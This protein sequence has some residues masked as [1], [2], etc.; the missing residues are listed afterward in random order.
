MRAIVRGVNEGR[1]GLGNIY[2]WASGDGGQDDDCNCDGYAA[3]M[4]TISINSA[5]NNGE[6]AHYDESCSSTLASTFSNGAKDPHTGVRNSLYDSKNRFHWNMNGVGLEFNHLFGYGVLD[7]GAMVALAKIW[8]TVPPRYHCEAGTHNKI[9]RIPSNESLL[10]GITTKACK[11]TET[12]VNYIEH[13]Q[14]VI[15]LNATR[16][17]DVTLFLISPMGTRS[18]ILSRRPK[19]DDS[20]DGFTKWPFMTTHTWGEDPKGRWQLEVK[21]EGEQPQ[22]G[23]LIEWTLMI[24][25]TKE[26]PYKDL[27]VHDRNSKLAVVKK[28]HESAFKN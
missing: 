4:W 9:M 15:T 22:S 12:E 14:A 10:V 1:N 26:P 25:G 7:A 18:M 2:V 5:I 3:S 23:F 19:D 20:R 28:A 21:F 17:G 11:N 6:N 27:P 24:H 8:K 13:V 16:R